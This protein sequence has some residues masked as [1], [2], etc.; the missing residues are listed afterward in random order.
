MASTLFPWLLDSPTAQPPKSSVPA[1]AKAHQASSEPL[2]KKPAAQKALPIHKK[3]ASKKPTVKGSVAK[4]ET[5]GPFKLGL[6]PPNK[7]ISPGSDCSGRRPEGWALAKL[8]VRN[9]S[10]SFSR[11]VN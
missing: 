1:A 8:G 5:G 9:F 3:P 10:T 2:Q 7:V 11:H 6:A 4:S